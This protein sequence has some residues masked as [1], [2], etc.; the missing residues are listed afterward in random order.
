MRKAAK[1]D[2]QPP[3]AARP[4]KRARQAAHAPEKRRRKAA[5]DD[6]FRVVEAALALS[7]PPLLPT[8]QSLFRILCDVFELEFPGRL[9]QQTVE[10]LANTINA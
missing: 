10:Q 2:P 7:L 1:A 9:S 5:A 4:V 3:D 6:A 8:P